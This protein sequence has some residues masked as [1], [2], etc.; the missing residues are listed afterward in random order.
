MRCS[1]LPGKYREQWLY[2]PRE[3]S[4]YEKDLFHSVE[5]KRKMGYSQAFFPVFDIPYTFH[6][7]QSI[8][9]IIS[10]CRSNCVHSGI[11][12]TEE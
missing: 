11:A 9:K 12:K 2:N 5:K 10:G 4:Q 8:D 7:V 1:R 3:I 6:N